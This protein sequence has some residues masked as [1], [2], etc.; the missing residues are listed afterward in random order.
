MGI[1]NEELGIEDWFGRLLGQPRLIRR[2]D[3]SEIGSL[4]RCAHV[5]LSLAR[6]DCPGHGAW[7]NSTQLPSGSSTIPI[8]TPGR[9]SVRGRTIFR[10][11]A[12]TALSTSSK[13]WMVI[14]Q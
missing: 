7:M 13:L 11:A 10:P 14:V 12:C 6:A 5:D 3:P 1:D 2:V 9:T 8:T 4:L